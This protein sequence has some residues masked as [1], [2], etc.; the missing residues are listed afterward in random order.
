V[1]YFKD[2]FLTG[3]F[4]TFITKKIVYLLLSLVLLIPLSF[5]W[6]LD[7]ES[8]KSQGLVGELQSGYLA[9]I[10]GKDSAEVGKL[11]ST[12]NS[13][14]KAEYQKIAKTSG[15]T[16]SAVEALA[17][18]KAIEKTISGNYVQNSNGKMQKK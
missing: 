3:E 12:I 17:G 5:A 10:E 9:P 6:A 16:L 1:D 4:M 2:I 7:L 14:R 11:V 15:T 13:K 18:K 8:A